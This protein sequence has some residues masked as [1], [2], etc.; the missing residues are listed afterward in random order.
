MQLPSGLPSSFIGSVGAIRYHVKANVHRKGMHLATK[1]F[2]PFS[3]VGIKDL[4]QLP[5]LQNPVEVSKDKTF[6]VLFWKSK[7]LTANVSINKQAF[8]SGENILLSGA[9]DNQSDVKIKECGVKL[10][11]QTEYRATTGKKRSDTESV[12]KCPQPAIEKET[13]TDWSNVSVFVPC[14]P[15]SDLD[16]CQIINTKYHLLVR[17]VPSGLHTALELTFPITI[18]TIPYQQNVAAASASADL[19]PYGSVQPSYEV[20]LGG[21]NESSSEKG[22]QDEEEEDDDEDDEEKDGEKNEEDDDVGIKDYK[23]KYPTFKILSA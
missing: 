23:P 21:S 4:N 8:V 22:S 17:I 18:G 14:L 7:P 9:I 1:V 11:K 3:V 2:L 5:Q 16:G 6:G 15:P 20:Y 12:Y 13:K 10:I 19:P